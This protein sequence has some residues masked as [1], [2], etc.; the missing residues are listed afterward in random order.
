MFFDF[1]FF[2]IN[3]ASTKSYEHEK[4]WPTWSKR[5]LTPAGRRR[6]SRNLLFAERSCEQYVQPPL[7]PPRPRLMHYNARRLFLLFFS[8]S[9]H[10]VYIARRIAVD[11]A[12]VTSQQ[13]LYYPIGPRTA[14]GQAKR[15]VGARW[16][17]ARRLN[18]QFLAA[19]AL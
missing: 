5:L 2:R 13:L 16:R 14:G 3:V 18:T 1:F 7:P 8:D 15:V 4:I 9:F 17:G 12:R 11:P 6:R 10:I 19:G